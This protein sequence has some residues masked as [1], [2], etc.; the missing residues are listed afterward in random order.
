[1]LNTLKLLLP[2]LMPSWR[3]FSE[4]APSPRI[5]IAVLDKADSEDAAWHEFRPRPD[6]VSPI[7]MFF[8][9][10]YNAH[11]NEGLFLMSCA[12]RYTK[13]PADHSID[14]IVTRIRTELECEVDDVQNYPFMRFRLVFVHRD[15]GKLLKHVTFVSTVYSLVVGD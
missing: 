3:F 10:F 13:S 11:W 9:M 1:M 14:E 5:E 6:H 12:E 8:R 2:A 4:I 7:Q 15:G